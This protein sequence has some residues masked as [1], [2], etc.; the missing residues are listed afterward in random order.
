MHRPTRRGPRKDWLSARSNYGRFS[1]RGVDGLV[2]I[3]FDGTIREAGSGFAVSLPSWRTNE[4]NNM[5]R[6]ALQRIRLAEV[7]AVRRWFPAG[8]RVLEIGGGDGYQA[9][10]IA[11]WGHQVESIDIEPSNTYFPVIQYDGEQIPFRSSTFDVIFSSNVL[12]HLSRSKLPVLLSETRRVLRNGGRAIHVL[13]SPTWRLWTSITHYPSV[14]QNQMRR[15]RSGST[16]D[17]VR[18]KTSESV[19]PKFLGRFDHAL[20]GIV[21]AHGDY[22]SA[23]SELYYYW[24]RRWKRVFERAEF[25]VI[26]VN[27]N[28]L[29]YSGYL[30]FPHLTIATRRRLSRLLG[31]SCNVFILQHE[32][33][34]TGQDACR[35]PLEVAEPLADLKECR[36][37][38][39]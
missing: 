30:I 19:R 9:S 29:L 38:L 24:S 16:R 14:V 22:P 25:R 3:L 18:P 2:Q 7:A 12:E 33:G 1:R 11:D 13:P 4:E 34:R 39:I 6:E 26:V 23:M 17:V 32:E 5:D 20:T 8:S 37:L 28:G 21:R 35:R 15:M 10:V 36:R 31:S 27:G